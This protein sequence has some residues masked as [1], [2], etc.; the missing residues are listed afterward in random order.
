MARQREEAGGRNPLGEDLLSCLRIM[1]GLEEDYAVG[2]WWKMRPDAEGVLEALC[3]GGYCERKLFAAEWRL[4]EKG[5]RVARESVV[6]HEL[7]RALDALI[8]YIKER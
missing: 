5:R 6:I 4:T 7:G 2:F 1:H 8:V 3:D